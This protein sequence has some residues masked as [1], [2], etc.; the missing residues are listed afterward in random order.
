MLSEVFYVHQMLYYIFSQSF[1]IFQKFASKLLCSFDLLRISG[2]YFSGMP[3]PEHRNHYKHFQKSHRVSWLGP[4]S[5]SQHIFLLHTPEAAGSCP[6]SQEGQLSLREKLGKIKRPPIPHIFPQRFSTLATI[7]H[8]L[9][10]RQFAN[11]HS[12]HGTKIKVRK[13]YLNTFMDSIYLFFTE[14]YAV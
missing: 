2:P 3:N 8:K 14:F 11:T 13:L 4:Y 6:C 7:S 12:W 9:W 5:G 10:E 1:L